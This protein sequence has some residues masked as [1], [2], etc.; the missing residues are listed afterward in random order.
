LVGQSMVVCNREIGL[1]QFNIEILR[2]SNRKL[3]IDTF[4]YMRS[5]ILEMKI[6]IYFQ[7]LKKYGSFA[8]AYV[9]VVSTRFL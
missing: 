1:K 5:R 4:S 7:T 9:T 6:T 3:H 8:H 2:K